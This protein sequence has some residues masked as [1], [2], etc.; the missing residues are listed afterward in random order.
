MIV[1]HA[2]K[3]IFFAVPRTATHSVR[4]ALTPFLAEDDW[5]QERLS[6]QQVLPVEELA[7]A[8]HGH[9][10]VRAIQ[11]HLNEEQWSSYY[12]FAIVRHPY[13]R[14]VSACAFLNRNNE[15]FADDPVDWMMKAFERERFVRRVLVRPQVDMLVNHEGK[16]AL[17]FIGR[18]EELDAAIKNVAIRTGLGELEL[19]RKNSSSRAAVSRYLTTSLTRSL[20]EFYRRD[21]EM[22]HYEAI[23]S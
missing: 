23:K 8:G 18:Y 13:D 2:H 17:D 1:S 21:F 12:K 6:Q 11:P 4:A 3:F 5:R 14:F 15:E 10:G 22:L 7:R 16:L 19:P 9:I 20:N